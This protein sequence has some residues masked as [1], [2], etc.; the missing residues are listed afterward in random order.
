MIFE[1][2]A[3]TEPIRQGDI[4]IGIPFCR[5]N[6]EKIPVFITS[7][8]LAPLQWKDIDSDEVKILASLERADG[9]VLTQDCDCLRSPSIS[10]MKIVNWEK[11]FQTD[12][13]WMN[14][15]IELSTKKLD[16]FYL[17][18]D[19]KWDLNE[20][21]IVEFETVFQ[22]DRSTIKTLRNL[23]KCRLNQE[24]LEHF[25]WKV[26]HFFRRYSYDEYYALASSEMDEYEIKHSESEEQ[27]IRRHYQKRATNP[28]S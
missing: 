2:V 15:I 12:K 5:F 28:S 26:S 19:E 9:I 22:L 11:S 18:I 13:N 1:A 17:P 21:K 6:L 24:A 14:A 27:F 10:F 25:R 3:E 7:G 4:F 23:R 16:S 20:R 8:N